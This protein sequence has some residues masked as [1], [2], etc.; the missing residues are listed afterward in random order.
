MNSR[1]LDPIDAILMKRYKI[2]D[3]RVLLQRLTYEEL[4]KPAEK[5]HRCSD[6]SSRRQ[7]SSGNDANTSSSRSKFSIADLCLRLE[8]FC[9]NRNAIIWDTDIPFRLG[10]S[11]QIGYV[12]VYFTS[13]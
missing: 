2:R 6:F 13:S 11:M 3:V 12:I 1:R 9:I 7:P 4:N 8:D 10:K 5:W